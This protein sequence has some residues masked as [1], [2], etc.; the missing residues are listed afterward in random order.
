[1]LLLFEPNTLNSSILGVSITSF[2]SKKGSLVKIG[3]CSSTFLTTGF[4][5]TGFFAAGFFAAGFFTTGFFAAGFLTAAVF[6]LT[7]LVLFSF[8][9][10]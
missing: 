1:L 8:F 3:F 5:T 2:F 4:L 9:L 6:F 7:A 10:V